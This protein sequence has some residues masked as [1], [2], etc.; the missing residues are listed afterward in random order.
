MEFHP[1]VPND[2]NAAL[3]Y[4]EAEGG[5]HLADR[6]EDELRGCL[7]AIKAGPTR[8]SFYQGSDLFRR[9]RLKGFPYLIVYRENAAIVR[10]TVLKHERRHPRFGMSRR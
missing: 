9:I 5:T 7:E 6:F 8:F 3:D 2:F 10:V 1:A 4:Y